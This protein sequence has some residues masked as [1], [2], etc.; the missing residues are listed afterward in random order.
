MVSEELLFYSIEC[1]REY[2]RLLNLTG[3]QQG[4][5]GNYHG[6]LEEA[7]DKFSLALSVEP[8]PEDISKLQNNVSDSTVLEVVLMDMRNKTSTFVKKEKNAQ[9]WALKIHNK[10]L[11][12][13]EEVY[14]KQV[15]KKKVIVY[16]FRRENYIYPGFKR[17]KYHQLF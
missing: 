4:K 7:R 16:S 2:N 17:R 1:E 8:T 10:E 6:L 12:E 5:L 9:D 3:E 11:K 13:M 15:R 14:M